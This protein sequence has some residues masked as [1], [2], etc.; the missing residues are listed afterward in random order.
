MIVLMKETAYGKPCLLVIQR[1]N[2][3]QSSSYVLLQIVIVNITT[4]TSRLW[5]TDLKYGSDC[6]LSWIQYLYHY[7]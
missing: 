1:I 4:A 6:I 5:A 2:H 3:A 7:M